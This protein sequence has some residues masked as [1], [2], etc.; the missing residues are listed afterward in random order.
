MA[1]GSEDIDLEDETTA[2]NRS[3]EEQQVRARAWMAGA[4]AAPC[5]AHRTSRGD[6]SLAIASTPPGAQRLMRES[7]SRLDELHDSVLRLGHVSSTISD[8]LA[9]HNELLDDIDQGVD[10]AQS[11]VAAVTKKTKEVIDY[12]GA[13]LPPMR[14]PSVACRARSPPSPRPALSPAISLLS[15]KVARPTRAPFALCSARSYFSS[16][17]RCC[18]SRPP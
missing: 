17:M 8:E 2:L 11:A 9:V 15:P 6:V 5:S 1:D 10:T 16:C 14:A 18:T 12:A 7:D 13:S 4:A 3:Y